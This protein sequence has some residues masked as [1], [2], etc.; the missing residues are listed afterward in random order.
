M[1]RLVRIIGIIATLILITN[2][3]T[4]AQQL[5]MFNVKDYG[6][7][8]D[9]RT[10][11]YAAIQ[12]AVKALNKNRSGHLYFPTGTYFIKPYH[13]TNVKYDNIVI[14]NIQGL[15]ISG[16]NAVIKMNGNFHRNVTRTKGRYK[17]SDKSII[18]LVVRNSKNVDI[19]DLEID[20]GASMMT[21][22]NGVVETAG[23]LLAINNCDGVTLDNLYIH[24]SHTDG[25]YIADRTKNLTATNLKL[26]NNARQG[27]SII[28]LENGVISNSSFQYN[29]ITGKYGGHSPA[30]GL[31]IEPAA[32]GNKVNNVV[33]KNNTFYNNA[34]SQILV[35]RPGMTSNV[36]IMNNNIDAGKSTGSY[37]IIL[38][39]NNIVLKDNEI[40]AG[41]GYVMPMYYKFANS[42]VIVENNIIKSTGYGISADAK[43]KNFNVTIRNNTIEYTGINKAPKNFPYLR[44]SFDYSNNKLI[45]PSKYKNNN[46]SVLKGL[47]INSNNQIKNK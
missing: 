44:G 43:S 3:Q 36:T 4:Y 32:A 13:G 28:H 34:A 19:R 11:D 18:T 15:K 23:R 45:V 25:I 21:K 7:K 27:M 6:A 40:N 22:D 20:G 26:H 14:E 39:G 9:G 29:G 35:T 42:S 24:H 37:Q 47:K 17:Y 30:S 16:S 8:G 12:K 31:D 1:K 41:N 5:K 46:F 33:I 38:S 10:D 2:V